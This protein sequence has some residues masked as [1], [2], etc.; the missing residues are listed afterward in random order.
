[1]VASR[2]QVCEYL[3]VPIVDSDHFKP[4]WA[5][6]TGHLQTITG[7][8]IPFHLKQPDWTEKI[9]TPDQDEIFLDWYKPNNSNDQSRKL[10]I[11][12]HGLESNSRAVYVKR[13]SNLL[14]KNNWTVLTWSYRGCGHIMNKTLR[15]YHSGATDDLHTVVSHANQQLNWDCISL[16]GFSLGGNLVLKYS[17]EREWEFK[18]KLNG[19]IAISVPCHLSSSA[20]QLAK[21]ENK[22]YMKRFLK[23]LKEKIIRKESQ[24]PGKLNLDLLNGI[25][26]F[27]EFDE[28]YTAAIHGFDS[29]EDYYQKSSSLQ[30]FNNITSPALLINAKDDPFLSQEC[31]PTNFAKSS[32]NFFLETPTFGG[33]VG[34]ISGPLHPSFWINQ[35]CLQFLNQ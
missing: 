6:R 11:V 2:V 15:L 12:C 19:T 17:G 31:F 22:I 26:T 28:F 35:R 9:Q 16:I 23:S 18:P 7:S 13:I 33:H 1:M 29:A 34:F 3:T 21:D 20:K 14:I 4:H 24:F 32:P 8:L 10:A 25:S 27:H 5:F 30:F